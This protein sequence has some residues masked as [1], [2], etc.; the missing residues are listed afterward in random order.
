[1][2]EETARKIES[3]LNLPPGSMDYP[4]EQYEAQ[5]ECHPIYTREPVT[6]YRTAHYAATDPEHRALIDEVV[7][8]L[9]HQ[10]V[11]RVHLIRELLSA[12]PR[13]RQ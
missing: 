7:D 4:G 1:M 11:E 12:L 3:V 9:L 13:R 2:S 5:G 10:P 8:V 6:T